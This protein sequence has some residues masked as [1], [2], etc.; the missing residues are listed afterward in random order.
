MKFEK[1]I[2]SGY[3]LRVC[4]LHR[5]PSRPDVFRKRLNDEEQAWRRLVSV[6]D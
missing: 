3:T 1:L 6:L 5:A 4:A 2:S